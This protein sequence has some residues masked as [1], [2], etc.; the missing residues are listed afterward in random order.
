M[1]SVVKFMLAAILTFTPCAV[2]L[3]TASEVS[4]AQTNKKKQQKRRSTRA[5]SPRK[6]K[7]QSSAGTSAAATSADVRRQQQQNASAIKETRRQITLNTRETER[8]LNNLQLVQGEITDCNARIG[9]IN[10]RLDSLGRR[11]A[12]VKDSIAALDS[13]LKTMT[14]V[15]AKALRKSQ[16]R[17]NQTS[18]LA[19]L[20]SSESFNQAY[21]RMSAVRQFGKWRGRHRP[22]N[23]PVSSARSAPPFSVSRR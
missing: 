23:R 14:D 22:T 2:P 15:Y 11:S 20:L 5:K 7:K 8:Q 1:K 12:T 9:I 13:R 4:S 6:G 16:G 17:R 21:R 18:Q 10:Q 3:L 19:F